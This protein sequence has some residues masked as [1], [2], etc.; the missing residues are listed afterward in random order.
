MDYL[1]SGVGYHIPP[2]TIWANDQSGQ[3]YEIFCQLVWPAPDQIP[4]QY[5][6]VDLLVH[7]TLASWS[8][9]CFHKQHGHE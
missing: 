1:F 9:L 5:D 4:A 6:A 7:M 2:A 3:Y 8:V